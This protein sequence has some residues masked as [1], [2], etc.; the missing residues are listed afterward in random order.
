MLTIE[1]FIGSTARVTAPQPLLAPVAAAKRRTGQTMEE[2][3]QELK[4]PTCGKQL[5]DRQEMDRPMKE[6]QN[7]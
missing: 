2:R 5:N 7:R 4:C 1:C 6:H 3:K